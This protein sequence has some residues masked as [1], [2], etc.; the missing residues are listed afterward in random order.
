MPTYYVQNAKPRGEDD[1]RLRVPNSRTVFLEAQALLL[2]V[3]LLVFNAVFSIF[4]WWGDADA[5]GM[6]EGTRERLTSS[7]FRT[8][9]LPVPWA[10]AGWIVVFLLQFTWLI[11]ACLYT[12]RQGV[13]R[14]L[15]PILY[16]I[17]WVAC[18][19][20]VGY[21]YT[22]GHSTNELSLALIAVEAIL[23]CLCVAVVAGYLRRLTT[24]PKEVPFMDKWFTHLITVNGLA[25][26]AAWT[27]LSTL[28]HIAVVLKEDS[29]IHND[30]IGTCLL[31][32]LS[33]LIIGY[34][35]LEITI[36]DR[37]LRYVNAVYPAVIWWLVGTL[38]EH[39]DNDFNGISR[40]NLFV[41][42][43]V[44][45]V[46]VLMVVHFLLICVFQRTRPSV[47]S[48]GSDDTDDVALI[49]Y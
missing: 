28:L 22:V 26:Y 7:R 23:L 46:G 33:A 31:S 6:G 3:V 39:W 21:V 15:H 10:F 36:L 37:Y 32:L 11:H 5:L 2:S 42:V 16:P 9:F 48:G 49:P 41:F 20:N 19:V 44:L 34:F 43:L 35:L 45:V 38:A 1:E 17:F 25:F 30:T 14:T 29:D 27:V 12:C 24:G 8:P 40:N 18:C 13:E 47:G 4:S